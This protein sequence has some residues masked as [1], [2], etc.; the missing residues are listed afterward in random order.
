VGVLAIWR[1]PVKAMLGERIAGRRGP[2]DPRL[3]ACRAQIDATVARLI[4][5]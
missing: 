3:Q 4:A 1:Y 2:T 5:P